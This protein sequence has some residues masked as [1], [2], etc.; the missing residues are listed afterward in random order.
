MISSTKTILAA[1]ALCAAAMFA[2]CQKQEAASSGGESSSSGGASKVVIKMGDNIPDRN[3]GVGA[4]IEQMNASFKQEHPEVEFEVESYGDQPWQEKV[5]IYAT[6]NRLPDIMKFWPFPTLMGPLVDSGMLMPLDQGKLAAYKFAPG[7]LESNIYDGKLYGIPMSMDFWVLYVNKSL[8]E[9]AGVEIPTTWEDIMASVPKFKAIGVVPVV[10]DGKEGWPLC[11]MYDS[12]LQRINGDFTHIKAATDDRTEKFTDSDFVKAAEYLQTLVKAGVFN[13]NLT[14]S[15]YGDARNTFGQGRAAMYM[16]GSFEMGLG[17]DNS[18]SEDFRNSLDV[19][20]FP[21]IEGGKGKATDLLAW[22]GGNFIVKAD[23]KN[24]ELAMQWIEMAARDFGRLA[25]EKKASF[26]PVA[27]EALPEDNRVSKNL[28]AISNSATSA[29]G[30][31]ALDRLD[32]IFKEDMQEQV[33][34]LCSL[35]VTPEQFAKTVDDS[36]Q[37]VYDDRH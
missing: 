32:S 24:K 17:T 1:G 37:R 11:E 3:N 30:T 31:P 2:G 6:A 28:L 18:F 14:T 25:W 4:V 33:R 9:K 34:Q 22:F 35:L 7:A 12:I 16:M 27:V 26:P 5:K 10:T 15:D 8:F 20:P 21:V 36:A 29:S 23:T 13:E 19:I